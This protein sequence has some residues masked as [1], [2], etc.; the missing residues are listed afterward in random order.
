MN[1][2]NLSLCSDTRMA[3]YRILSD[4]YYKPDEQLLNKLRNVE[5]SMGQFREDIIKSIPETDQLP[6]LI[7]DY[8]RLFVGPFK[9]LAAPYGSVYLDDPQAVQKDSLYDLETRYRSLG[10]DIVL[11]EGPDHITI[12]LE[13]MYF[14][15][16]K[17]AEA[18]DKGLDSVANDYATRQISFLEEHLTK[19]LPEFVHNIQRHAQTDFY[20]SIAQATRTFVDMDLKG[21]CER[22]AKAAELIS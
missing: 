19:W 12:E 7:I 11:K 5:E 1:I 14:L 3:L 8:S 9:L 20:K 6:S 22:T 17:E 18:F 15:I 13:F 4:C 21:L 2:T 16:F 10:L